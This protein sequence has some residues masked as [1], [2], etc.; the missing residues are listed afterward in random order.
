MKRKMRVWIA[1]VTICSLLAVPV[2]AEERVMLTELEAAANS[3]VLSWTDVGAANYQ[4]WRATSPN[5]AYLPVGRTEET[6]YQDAGLRTGTVYY[7]KV[8]PYRSIEAGYGAFS[9]PKGQCCVQL[10]EAWAEQNPC[11]R[12]NRTI[13]VRGLMLHSVG[14]P[15]EQAA[16]FAANWNRMDAEVLVHAVIDPSGSVWQLADWEMRCWHCGGVGN[17]S[18]IGVEMTEPDE[19]RYLK[20]DAFVWR[21]D[22]DVTAIR[23]YNTAVALFAGLCLRYELDPLQDIFSHREA[24]TTG[25]A[26]AHGDPEHLWNGLGFSLDMDTFRRDVQRKMNGTYILRNA[27]TEN[28]SIV[29]VSAGILNVRSGPGTHYSVTGQ[30]YRGEKAVVSEV[31]QQEDHLWGK[32][33]SGDWI[34]LTYTS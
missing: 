20:A 32:L 25:T 18:L 12:Q 9:E 14:C 26:S 15:Q 28:D 19:L 23:N 6:T 24:G 29:T 7:Y 27:E 13:T 4:I 17:D 11:Y 3:I 34:S 1:M 30:L 10:V 31:L 2:S 16:V 8:R 5:G 21:S 33:L 22:A